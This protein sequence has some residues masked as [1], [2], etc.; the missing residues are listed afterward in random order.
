[1][2]DHCITFYAS[3]DLEPNLAHPDLYKGFVQRSIR[4]FLESEQFAAAGYPA[5]L[6]IRAGSLDGELRV[7]IEACPDKAQLAEGSE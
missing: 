6:S 5:A 4:A 1:M 2:L 3:T 7:A